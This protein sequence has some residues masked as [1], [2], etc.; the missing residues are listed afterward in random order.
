[1]KLS[2]PPSVFPRQLPSPTAQPAGIGCHPCRPSRSPSPPPSRLPPTPPSPLLNLRSHG[3]PPTP[4][5]PIPQSTAQQ[6]ATHAFQPI[7]QPTIPRTA[8]HAAQAD[9]PVHRPAGCHP[10]LPA[11]RPYEPP[12]TAQIRA[13]LWPWLPFVICIVGVD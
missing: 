5:R 11:H 10:R 1:M 3:L 6:A 4:P 12:P 7:A 2:P 8:T 9:P 13:P